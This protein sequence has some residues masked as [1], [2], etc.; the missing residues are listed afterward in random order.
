MFC[1]GWGVERGFHFVRW[2]YPDKSRWE[3]SAGWGGSNG[4]E[5]GR[6]MVMSMAS[7][8]GAAPPVASL[9]LM[10]GGRRSGGVFSSVSVARCPSSARSNSLLH[11]SFLSSSS[12]TLSFPSSFSGNASQIKENLNYFI[13]SFVHPLLLRHFLFIIFSCF[14]SPFF[15]SLA[16]PLTFHPFACFFISVIHRSSVS[17]F[18]TFFLHQFCSTRGVLIVA[19]P[20]F[21]VLV[22]LL[23]SFVTLEFPFP[24]LFIINFWGHEEGSKRSLNWC[25]VWGMDATWDAHVA[26]FLLPN[27]SVGVILG[28]ELR[29]CS[30]HRLVLDAS[31]ATRFGW[32]YR[33]VSTWG[34]GAGKFPGHFVTN[35][36]DGVWIMWSNNPYWSSYRFFLEMQIKKNS[37]S[38][39]NIFGSSVYH[40]LRRF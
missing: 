19:P 11:T 4:G 8:S 36:T 7:L 23:D 6:E 35:W 32:G 27:K 28:I 9:G 40:L 26:R 21:T 16:F 24:I 1:T 22:Q 17:L 29:L 37:T 12:G 18:T 14:R 13:I 31:N 34:D 38:R 30:L 15:I 39:V 10:A 25:V 3:V 2:P 33:I 5:G 20:F